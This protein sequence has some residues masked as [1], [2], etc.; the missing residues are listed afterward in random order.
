LT[1]SAHVY[2]LKSDAGHELTAAL[3]ALRQGET[4]FTSRIAQIALRAYLSKEHA[5]VVLTPREHEC[6]SFWRRARVTR[7]WPRLLTSA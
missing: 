4:F 5:S 2:V 3:R 7:K 6:C 1:P